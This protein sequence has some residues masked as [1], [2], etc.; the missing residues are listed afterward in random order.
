[1]P[2]A[3]VECRHNVDSESAVLSS[4]SV[5]YRD[6]KIVPVAVSRIIDVALDDRSSRGV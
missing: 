5:Y 2:A 4:V 6:D 3:W 1:M